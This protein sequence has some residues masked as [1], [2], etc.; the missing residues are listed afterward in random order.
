MHTHISTQASTK[1]ATFSCSPATTERELQP[2]D[3]VYQLLLE[4]S[5]DPLLVVYQPLLEGSYNPLIK[6][7]ASTGRKLLLPH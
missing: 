2:P 4:G 7:L 3:L 5:Y 6:I 1:A